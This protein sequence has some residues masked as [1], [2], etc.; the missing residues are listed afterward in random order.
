MSLEE[1]IYLCFKTF[2]YHFLSLISQFYPS[3]PLNAYSTSFDL[4][5]SFQPDMWLSTS[6]SQSGLVGSD[7]CDQMAALGEMSPYFSGEEVEVSQIGPFGSYT[8]EQVNTNPFSFVYDDGAGPSNHY[9]SPNFVVQTS[10][11][12]K[13]KKY[14]QKIRS[15][16][17][18]F[19]LY[20]ARKR[21]QL[22]YDLY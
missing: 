16:L 13:L 5:F 1:C 12:L 9:S 10:S 21:A 20:V 4:P 6:I 22:F 18:W 14:W 8:L 2:C 17:K 3:G 11:K 15:T 19:M 7:F